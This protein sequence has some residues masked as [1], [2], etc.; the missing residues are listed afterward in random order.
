[1]MIWSIAAYRAQAHALEIE[2][3]AE[4]P[5][6]DEYDAAQEREMLRGV[7]MEQPSATIFHNRIR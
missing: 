5:L 7:A 3:T 4:R 6:A 2:A 1:M